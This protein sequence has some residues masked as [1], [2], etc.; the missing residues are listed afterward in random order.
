MTLL[1]WRI[2]IKKQTAFKP[3]LLCSAVIEE[4]HLDAIVA[5][6]VRRKG[7]EGVRVGTDPASLGEAMRVLEL[8]REFG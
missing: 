8:R 5:R 1:P 4:I 6:P 2:E 7:I 3:A